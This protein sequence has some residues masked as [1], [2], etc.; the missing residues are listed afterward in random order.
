MRPTVILLGLVLAA[1]ACGGEEVTPA[2]A[3]A[4]VG[5]WVADVAFSP[6]GGR[7]ALAAGDGVEI[8]SGQ[9][10]GLLSTISVGERVY[11]LE[12]VSPRSLAVGTAKGSVILYDVTSGKARWEAHPFGARVWDLAVEP[13]GRYLAGASGDGTIAVIDLNS[14]KTLF[15]DDAHPK[16]ALSCAFSPEGDLLATGGMEG[17]I[18]LWEVPTWKRLKGLM[19]HRAAVWGLSFSQDGRLI[20]ASSDG[21][22]IIWDPRSG[23]KIRILSPGAEKVRKAFFQPEGNLIA[24]AASERTVFLWSELEEGYVGKLGGHASGLWT[25]RFSRDGKKLITVSVD[26]KAIM[27]DVEKL[28]SLRPVIRSVFYS[29]QMGRT[30]YIMVAFSDPNGDV[31]RIRIELLQGNPAAVWVTSGTGPQPLPSEFPLHA[32]G[33]RGNFSF[34]LRVDVPQRIV[35]RIVV[36]DALGLRSL[37]EE[38]EIEAS[39]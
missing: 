20:S 32:R 9:D 3:E 7:V 22:A 21:T 16:G 8:R 15:A 25:L 2:L 10:L 37:P 14:R 30:Q 13:H 6:D 12:F 11:S 35:L 28:L 23:E 34:G 26:G 38:V 5:L 29:R 39:G 4:D 17:R 1:V 33:N 27:W 19:G 24:L 36:V 18:F 31:S